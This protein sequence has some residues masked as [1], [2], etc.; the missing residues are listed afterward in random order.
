MAS[1]RLRLSR[2]GKFLAATGVYPPQV[3][4]YELSELSMKF[5]RHMDC[6]VVQ[7]MYAAHG[8]IKAVA[9]PPN[10]PERSITCGPRAARRNPTTTVATPR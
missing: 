10:A 3:K 7:L 9:P 5:E 4:V 2:D 8:R 6:E 1:S